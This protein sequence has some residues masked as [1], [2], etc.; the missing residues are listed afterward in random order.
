MQNYIKKVGCKEE[1]PNSPTEA[2]VQPAVSEEVKNLGWRRTEAGVHDFAHL[3][4]PFFC[5]PIINSHTAH[6]E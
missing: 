4:T 6:T 3:S 1:D 5:H 2:A